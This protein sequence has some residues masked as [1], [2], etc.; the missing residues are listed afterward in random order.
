MPR[1]IIIGAGLTGLST[2]YHLKKDFLVLEK[3][4]SAGGVCASVVKDGSTFDYSGHFLH[5]H[6]P[7][8][9][10]LLD[11]L[12][13]SKL[14]AVSRKAAIH[15][16]GARLPYPFQANLFYLPE[17]IK[18][19]CLDGFLK[20]RPSVSRLTGQKFLNWSNSVF[21]AS[22]TKHFMKPYNE[23]LWTVSSKILTADWVAPFVPRPSRQEIL[24]GAAA[25][26]NRDFGYNT[27][28]YYPKHGGCRTI[29]D[30]FEDKV[31]GISYNTASERIDLKKRILTTSRG[32]SLHFEH[33]VSTQPLVELLAS[34]ENLPS[35]VRAAEKALKWNSV[36]CLNLAFESPNRSFKPAGGSHWVYFPEKKYAFYRTGFYTNVISSMAP[37][38]CFSMYVEIS[39]K[40]S[41]RF[42]LKRSL[43]QTLAGLKDCGIIARGAKPVTVNPLPIPYAYVIYDNKRSGALKLIRAY[44]KA[45]RVSSIGRYGAWEYTFMERSISDGRMAA[46][47][48]SGL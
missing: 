16:H 19:E 48:L 40:S 41:E 2:A 28:F 42:D 37:E 12:L 46:A 29:I 8:T 5:L 47:R 34:I 3:T 18:A 7:R 1:T 14:A 43:A 24:D 13:P 21:G 6:D 36:D 22:I 11:R 4:A 32:D 38:R 45:N 44:L 10:T 23:K 9:K 27:S 17:K 39:R 20:S 15:T 26:Q 31:P 30:G 25:P 35:A 33:L